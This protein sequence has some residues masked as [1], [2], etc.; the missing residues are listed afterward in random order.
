MKRYKYE[1]VIEKW[2]VGGI[3]AQHSFNAVTIHHSAVKSQGVPYNAE[4][5]IKAYAAW[6][7]KQG[8]KGITYHFVIPADDSDVIY[9]TNYVSGHTWHNSNYIGNQNSLAVMVDGNFEQERPTKKQLEKLKQ[10]LDDLNNNWFSKNGWYSFEKQIRTKDKN[11]YR[12]YS[13]SITVSSLHTHREVAQP[14]HGTACPGRHLQFY[15][16]DYR[17]KA[18]NVDWGASEPQ[19]PVE[20]CEQ[21]KKEINRLEAEKQLLST[22][23]STCRNEQKA[24]RKELKNALNEIEKLNKRI[25][26]LELSTK[27]LQSKLDKCRAENEDLKKKVGF[28]NSIL[29]FIK[30]ILSW[31]IKPKKTKK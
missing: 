14:G 5:R 22:E 23:L 27:T 21:Y 3:V 26:V 12:T 8:N 13:D 25:N 11:A 4:Q 2:N 24:T 1:V 17:N 6:H 31:L 29:N 7:R 15:I 28:L 16:D 10:I 9:C 30:N 19:P 18:G 20:D